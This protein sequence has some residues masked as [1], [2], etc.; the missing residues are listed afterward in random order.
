MT[1][2][3][4]ASGDVVGVGSAGG[5]SSSS[6][7]LVRSAGAEA[8]CA[9]ATAESPSPDCRSPLQAF[10]LPIPGRAVEEGP[11]GTVRVDFQSAAANKRWDVYIDDAVVCTT[12]CTKWM[13]PARPVFMRTREEGGMF[14]F[15]GGSDKVKVGR[16]GNGSSNAWKIDAH[17]TSSGKLVTGITFTALGGTAILAGAA[18]ASLGCSREDEEA[19]C[20]GGLW[21]M[22]IGAAVT[23]GGLWL[24][25]DSFPYAKVRPSESLQLRPAAR[26]VVTP[27]GI[28]GS[29]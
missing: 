29:F 7:R 4:S 14:G 3:G 11:P 28:A 19:K 21:S 22:G 12:P 18:L 23:G 16:V 9:N 8:E 26:L 24:L 25:F 13:D 15:G 5:S 20:D 6:A 2:G 27:T 17:G 10:L 1:S